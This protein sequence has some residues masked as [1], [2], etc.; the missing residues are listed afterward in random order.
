MP[1]AKKC[2]FGSF[3]WMN[4]CLENRLWCLEVNIWR[5]RSSFCLPCH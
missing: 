4:F 5:P 3:H 2:V 1:R